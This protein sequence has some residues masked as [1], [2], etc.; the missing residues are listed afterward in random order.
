MMKLVLRLLGEKSWRLGTD[1]HCQGEESWLE[2]RLAGSTSTYK[3]ARPLSI[4][5]V[6]QFP[7][8]PYRW[9]PAGSQLVKDEGGVHNSSF[10]ITKK[11]VEQGS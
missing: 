4:A 3:R 7:E 6:F 5:C 9:N 10:C 8:V 2:P 11:S 1:S